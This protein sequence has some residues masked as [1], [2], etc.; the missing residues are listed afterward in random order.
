VTAPPLLEL[1][2][3][4]LFFD[5]FDG[6]A[7]VLDD[8]SLTLAAGETLGVVG[9]SGCGK[10]VLAKSLLRLLPSPP[11]RYPRGS[12]AWRGEEVLAMTPA[13]LRRLRGAEVAMVFQDPMTFL[14]PLFTIGDQM[15]EVIREQDRARGG[16]VRSAKAAAARAAEVL[17]R[18]H[19]AD[20]P[21][22]LAS[23]PL[24]L[25]G[26]MRQRVLIGMAL[27]G[28]PALLVADE[29]TTALDVTVQAEI[30]RLVREQVEAMRLAVMLISHDLGVVAAVCQRVL[31]MYAGTVVEDAPTRELLRAPAHPYA[32]GLVAAVPRLASAT[33]PAGIPG[34][35]PNLLDPPPG[36]RFAPR[37]PRADAR[38]TAERPLLREVAPGRRA[39]CHYPEAVT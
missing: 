35:L 30:L 24:Q 19:M 7:H 8:V 3:L 29:P 39:A 15:A 21:R 22:V 23:H 25:S 4:D 32:R 38:C 13:R 5:G 2:G 26:G 12:I 17:A 9:E 36:C 16:P 6:S 28:E 10:S 37:C 27:S 20:P 18:L 34:Q 33:R 11:A 14:D 31:V 1:R